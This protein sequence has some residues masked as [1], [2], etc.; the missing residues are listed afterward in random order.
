MCLQKKKSSLE[1]KKDN[2]IIV[3]G[4]SGGG[5]RDVF[6]LWC[7]NF[8]GRKDR[9]SFSEEKQQA[10]AGAAGTPEKQFIWDL[11]MFSK[12]IIKYS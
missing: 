3:S 10:A 1:V 2:K 12:F 6:V 9:K 4:E 5:T 11:D 7:Q 8:G